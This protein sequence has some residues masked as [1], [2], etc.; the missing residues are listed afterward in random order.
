MPSSTSSLISGSGRGGAA[1]R[2]RAV[3][4]EL[5]ASVVLATLIARVLVDR[6]VRTEALALETRGVDAVLHEPGHDGGRAIL[7]ELPVQRRGAPVV[8]VTFDAHRRDLGMSREDLLHG[9]QRLVAVLADDLGAA[10]LE[11]DLVEDADLRSLDEGLRAAVP[12]R[13]GVGLAGL[14]RTRVGVVGDAVLVAIGIGAAVRLR[15]LRAD[16]R[17]RGAS[18]LLVEDAVLVGVE[19]RTAVLLRA[20]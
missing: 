8:G 17:D 7:A 5:D 4:V 14:V 18:V 1:G 9:L 6:A 20:L 15:V 11:L 12:L 10:G 19:L 13:V 3:D 2:S 16:A